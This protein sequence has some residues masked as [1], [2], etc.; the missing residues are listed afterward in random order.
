MGPVR[1]VDDLMAVGHGYQRSMILL[2]ALKLGVFRALAGGAFDAGV[3][4][5]RV[6]ADAERLS[7]LLDAL[8]ALGLVEKRGRRYR[9]AKP[10]HDLLLPGPR[11]K[12]SILLHHLDGWG[13]WGRLPSTI[14]AGRKPRGGAQGTWQENFIR[15]MEENALE[16]AAAV[17]WEIP[18]RPGS[19]CWT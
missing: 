6:G 14:R 5:R 17:A 9:N 11:S 10:A 1:N 16:R 4:A 18:L 8:A 15:G 13:E 3:L 7:I 12:E 19:G 2:A